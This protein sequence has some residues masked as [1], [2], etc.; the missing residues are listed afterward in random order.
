MPEGPECYIIAKRIESWIR[1]RSIERWSFT[2]GRYKVH[3]APSTMEEGSDLE[4]GE[5]SV[6]RVG[7][8]GKLIWIELDDK[9]YIL[10]TLGME[11]TWHKA[12]S[13]HC[14]VEVQLCQ[15]KGKP[16]RIWFRDQRHYGTLRRVSQS[17]WEDKL[18]KLGN[19]VLAEPGE[20]GFLTVH[21]WENLCE[22][23]KQW[24]L[25]KLLMCQ[26][27]L[28]GVGNYLKSEI[29][30]ES[31]VSP[32]RKISNCTKE[33]LENVYAATISIPRLALKTKLKLD[34]GIRGRFYKRI[35]MRKKVMGFNVLREKT[36][37]NRTTHWIP[38][39]QD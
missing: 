6:S 30:F 39:L 24:T 21:E 26:T 4:R 2:G 9:S 27:Q 3:G 11:G 37:D 25:P 14:D 18:Q 10:N 17:E 13:K 23:H 38:S 12:R 7:C 33:Q 34:C 15:T 20:S 8:K 35:Y 32:W 5:R 22:R 36:E 31:R 28:S 29:L 19:D 1:G 16:R